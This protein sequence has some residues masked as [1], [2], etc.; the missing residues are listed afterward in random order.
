MTWATKLAGDSFDLEAL[1]ESLVDSDAK[2]YREGQDFYLA[3]DEFENFDDAK[4]VLATANDMVSML[5]GGCRLALSSKAPIRVD[6][7]FRLKT[8][9]IRDAFVFASGRIEIRGR[10]RMSLKRA[11]G[12]VETHPESSMQH[13][14]RVARTDKAVANVLRLLSS[15]NFDWTNLYRVL[16]IISHDVGGGDTIASNGWATKNAMTLFKHTA[17]SPTVSGLAARHGVQKGQPP[18]KPMSAS[19]AESLITSIAHAWLR[20][21]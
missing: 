10:A 7:V 8:N 17:C 12:T 19:D 3:S 4:M 21:K 13:W 1:A 11:D 5:S 2:V 6:G 16:E 9:G 15:G 20:T 14:L 18:A